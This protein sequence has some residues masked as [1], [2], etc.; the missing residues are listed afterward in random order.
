MA[1]SEIKTN[2]QNRETKG[3]PQTNGGYKIRQR[4]IEIMEYTHIHIHQAKLKPFNK[5][6]YSRLTW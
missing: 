1:L 2:T 5:K 4:I 3:E 6:K